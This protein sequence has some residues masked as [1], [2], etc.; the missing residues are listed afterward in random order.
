MVNRLLEAFRRLRDRVERR[1]YGP[2]T[3]TAERR[4]TRALL[5]FCADHGCTHSALADIRASLGALEAGEKSNAVA[6]VKRIWMGKEG[7]G[8]WW[9]PAASPSETEEHAWAVF[10]ALVERWY[11]LMM[12]L[13]K[14]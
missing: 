13:D 5:K 3:F 2:N 4:A 14:K 6:A 12:L 8:D 7:F 9:P 1:V 11:R 10:E